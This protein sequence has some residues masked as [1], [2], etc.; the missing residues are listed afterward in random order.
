MYQNPYKTPHEFTTIQNA[1]PQFS[2][3][4]FFAMNAL[5][6]TV[7]ATGM[8]FMNQIDYYQTERQLP[9]R[10]ASY[11]QELSINVYPAILAIATMIGLPNLFAYLFGLYHKTNSVIAR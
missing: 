10:Y 1:N 5:W 4:R 2:W 6:I 11:D 9:R 8:Y 3:P 7:L